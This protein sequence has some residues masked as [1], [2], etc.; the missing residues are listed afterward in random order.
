LSHTNNNENQICES[1]IA[2]KQVKKKKKMKREIISALFLWGLSWVIV[3]GQDWYDRTYHP[4]NKEELDPNLERLSETCALPTE[5]SPYYR[6]VP[7]G[8]LSKNWCTG[9]TSQQELLEKTLAIM[10]L[11]TQAMELS[12]IVANNH[13][14][15]VRLMYVSSSGDEFLNPRV[16]NLTSEKI[17]CSFRLGSESEIQLS[18]PKYNSVKVRGLDVVWKTMKER[19]YF[20]KDSCTVQFLV[21]DMNGR[22]KAV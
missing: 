1:E 15:P 11:S 7:E 8:V 22:P 13:G 10:R 2:R 19:D 20:G 3:H 5:P 4:K 9:Y 12:G 6:Q 18:E 14:I 16:T 17:R 21:D